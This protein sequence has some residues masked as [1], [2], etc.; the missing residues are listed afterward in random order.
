VESN[1]TDADARSD[2]ASLRLATNVA[3]GG[4]TA[5]GVTGLVL[6]LTAPTVEF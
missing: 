6:V 3:W 1:N 5:A 2:A 4:A